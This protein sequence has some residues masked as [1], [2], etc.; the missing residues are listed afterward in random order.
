M[1]WCHVIMTNRQL[2]C[3]REI[4]YQSLTNFVMCYS[5]SKFS[6]LIS[7]K[8]VMFRKSW[9]FTWNK[10]VKPRIP[11]SLVKILVKFRPLEDPSGRG[12][13][14]SPVFRPLQS[15]GKSWLGNPGIF[16]RGSEPLY[17]FFRAPQV[18]NR[19]SAL[20]RKYVPGWYPR[21]FGQADGGVRGSRGSRGPFCP[22]FSSKFHQNFV[23][24]SSKFSKFHQNF[25]KIF[26]K[27]L[28]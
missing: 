28:Y 7:R 10:V 19:S 15:G 18:T 3:C 17:R 21:G 13:S 23:K 1:S 20:Y 22:T 6:C 26:I 12:V 9:S 11:K 14:R 5:S 16:F 24:I 27:N 25:V 2:Y 8:F 4:I